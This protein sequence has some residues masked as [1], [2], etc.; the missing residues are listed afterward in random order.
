MM[1]TAF[2]MKWPLKNL[3]IWHPYIA[4]SNSK[5]KKLQRHLN[6]AQLIKQRIF[7]FGRLLL[8]QCPY[9]WHELEFVNLTVVTYFQV[10]A[11]R[12][13]QVS[14]IMPKNH[15][16]CESRVARKKFYV[17]IAGWPYAA[18]LIAPIGVIPTGGGS[19][20]STRFS[21]A[22]WTVKESRFGC[23]SQNHLRKIIEVRKRLSTLGEI[24]GPGRGARN[25]LGSYSGRS[26]KR[27]LIKLCAIHS[28]VIGEQKGA[29]KICFRNFFTIECRVRLFWDR[30]WYT[31]M[32]RW[33]EGLRGILPEPER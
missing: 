19:I 3:D 26:G 7:S 17:I 8:E 5:L 25:H 29:E 24:T 32:G 23:Y 11:V 9:L 4:V 15:G 10:R 13:R 18:G 14:M 16:L 21:T 33:K 27:V 22:K 6:W 28:I 12:S 31:A 20:F 1:G 2:L 30:A